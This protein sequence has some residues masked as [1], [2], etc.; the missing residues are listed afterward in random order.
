M[1]TNEEKLK[2]MK[3]VEIL[4]YLIN[5]VLKGEFFEEDFYKRYLKFYKRFYIKK[6]LIKYLDKQY[7]HESKNNN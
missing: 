5:D 4:K 3:N 2:A 6:K 7:E 1:K